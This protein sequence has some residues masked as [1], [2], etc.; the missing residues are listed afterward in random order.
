M[1][2]PA[3]D[4]SVRYFSAPGRVEIGGNHTDHQHGRV[5]AAAV[6]LEITASVTRWDSVRQGD[7]SSAWLRKAAETIRLVTEVPALKTALHSSDILVDLG[8]LEVDPAEKGTAAA[9]VRG[10][11]AWF[12]EHGYPIG[13]F[14]AALSSS[15][16]IGAGLSS[17]AA[18]AVLVGNIFKGLFGGDVSL[19]EIAKAGK[20]AENVYFGKPCGLMDQAASSYGGLNVIDFADPEMPVVTPV[21]ADLSGYSMCV[22]NTG[23]SHADLT[24]DYAAATKE[25]RA[26]ATHFGKDFL[27]EICSDEFFSS[28][29]KLRYLGD[30]ANLRAIHFFADNERVLKQAAALE[31]GDMKAFLQLVID[32]GRSSLAYL[33]N[34][35]SPENPQ[36]QGLTL[37]LALSEKILE[38]TGAWR[39]H[40]GGFA[41]TI[42][43][44]VPDELNAEYERCMCAVFGNDSCHFLNIRNEGGREDRV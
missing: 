20:Y 19:M 12:V 44:F 17:S 23:G 14:D 30:R 18:F 40:G 9:L 1:S 3:T 33:Q 27:S 2:S 36:Q 5:L 22:V 15:I 7:D 42:L 6:G 13:G 43:A 25:M 34:V 28:V 32:S 24:P 11:A 39:V 35:Y 29:H 31:S 21:R 10:V 16:P 37:A 8:K 4:K 38:G 41:G 26:V